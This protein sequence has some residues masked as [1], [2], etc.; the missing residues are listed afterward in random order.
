MLPLSAAPFTI[1][2]ATAESG[3]TSDD[4]AALKVP[5][6]GGGCRTEGGAGAFTDEGGGLTDG[7]GALT[8]GGGALTDGGDMGS[9]DKL[10]QRRERSQFSGEHYARSR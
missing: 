8:D 9:L 4:V 5:D 2:R 7:G 10:A 6:D 3:G 1:E